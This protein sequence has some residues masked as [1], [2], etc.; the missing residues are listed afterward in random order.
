MTRS[1]AESVDLG[2]K[3]LVYGYYPE[4]NEPEVRF[5]DP[6]LAT[7][8]SLHPDGTREVCLDDTG[9]V[10]ANVPFN[11]MEPVPS[12]GSGSLSILEKVDMFKRARRP[13]TP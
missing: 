13:A 10:I 12:R 3:V 2:A 9:E 6:R 7:A 11:L 5:P 1:A 8:G 4:E